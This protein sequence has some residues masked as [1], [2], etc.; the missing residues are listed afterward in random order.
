[1]VSRKHAEIRRQNDSF[2]LNDNGSFNGTLVNEQRI[3]TP[4]PLYHNDKIQLGMGG[5]VLRFTAPS[6]I[7]PEGASLA[8]QRSIAIGQLANLPENIG[9]QTIAFDIGLVSQK[10]P[11]K[12][13][14]SAAASNVAGFRRQKRTD[15]RTR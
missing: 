9:S 15:C 12:A 5:P 4:T 14:S 3:S 8:G 11:K 7:A 6:L 2:T 13:I 1:M 10:T